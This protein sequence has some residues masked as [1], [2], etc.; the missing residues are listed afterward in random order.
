VSW[1]L[2]NQD[3]LGGVGKYPGAVDFQSDSKCAG[4]RWRRGNGIASLESRRKEALGETLCRTQVMDG[5][6][7]RLYDLKREK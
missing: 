3:V 5:R 6:R 4:G 2:V 1:T 7:R